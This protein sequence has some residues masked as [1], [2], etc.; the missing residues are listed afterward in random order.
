MRIFVSY[1][2][3]CNCITKEHLSNL[4]RKQHLNPSISMYIDLFDNP[5]GYNEGEKS[6]CC[7]AHKHVMSEIKKSDVVLLLSDKTVSPWVKSELEFANNHGIPV[8][9]IST[10]DIDSLLEDCEKKHLAL[11]NK[12]AMFENVSSL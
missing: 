6:L 8:I 3:L 9:S 2:L 12:I 11:I 7:P 5:F 4:R 1:S 10:E